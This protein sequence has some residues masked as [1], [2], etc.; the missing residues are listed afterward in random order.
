M[1]FHQ[2]KREYLQLRDFG[3]GLVKGSH[4][5]TNTF[6]MRQALATDKKIETVGID[7]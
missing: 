7:L 6:R 2:S 1:G 5:G 3:A 4:E